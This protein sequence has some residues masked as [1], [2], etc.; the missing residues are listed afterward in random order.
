M[1]SNSRRR[2]GWKALRTLGLWLVHAAPF[3]PGRKLD[4]V[5][6]LGSPGA[7]SSWLCFPRD[8]VAKAAQLDW[9]VRGSDCAVIASNRA[10]AP[11]GILLA[12]HRLR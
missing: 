10:A 11:G 4:W 1:L 5:Q 7:P 6:L 8:C 2:P 3:S 9:P 12:E